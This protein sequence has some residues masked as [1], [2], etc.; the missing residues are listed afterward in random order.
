[1]NIHF[2]THLFGRS[3]C[4]AHIRQATIASNEKIAQR[5]LAEMKEVGELYTMFFFLLFPFTFFQV[6]LSSAVVYIFLLAQVQELEKQAKAH[7]EE[8]F[9]QSLEEKDEKIS[10]LQTQVS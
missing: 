7:L 10:V 3:V 4:T 5:K 6:S 8:V 2:G 1:M 9:R